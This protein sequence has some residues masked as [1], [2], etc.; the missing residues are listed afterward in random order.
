MDGKYMAAQ[1]IT[2]VER[3]RRWSTEDKLRIMDEALGARCFGPP[4]RASIS[5]AM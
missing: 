1:I 4:A 3:R 2:T 5:P